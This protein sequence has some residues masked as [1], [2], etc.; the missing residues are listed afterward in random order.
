MAKLIIELNNGDILSFDCEAED[1]YRAITLIH[2]Y[3]H[4][5]LTNRDIDLADIKGMDVHV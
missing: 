2:K 5:P 1:G 3:H 4:L